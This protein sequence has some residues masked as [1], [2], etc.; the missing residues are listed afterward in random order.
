MRMR[1]DIYTLT[2]AGLGAACIWMASAASAQEPT[3]VEHCR[4][5]LDQCVIA[6]QVPADIEVCSAQEARCIAGEMQ[7]PVP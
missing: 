4:D 1:L 2:I 7:L 3:G 5:A 6:A